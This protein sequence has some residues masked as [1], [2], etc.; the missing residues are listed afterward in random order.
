M[1]F[2][3]STFGIL[4]GLMLAVSGVHAQETEQKARQSAEPAIQEPVETDNSEKPL[5]DAEALIKAGKPAEAYIL[6]EPLEFDRA[7]EIRFDYLLGIAALDS[8]KPDKATLAFERVLAEDPEYAGARLDMARAYYQLGDLSRAKT[9]FETVLNQNPS[10]VARATI[11][12]YLDSIAGFETVRK[13]RIVGY[14]E[15]AFGRDTNVNNASDFAENIVTPTPNPA[16]DEIPD[17]YFGFAAGGEINHS[18]NGN[19]RLYAGADMIKHNNLKQKSFN[20]LYLDE[21]VGVIYG[22]GK[23]RY[24]V[25]MEGG[26]KILGG[27]RYRNNSGFNAEWRH[28][29]GNSN[30]LN[31]FGQYV[32]YRFVDTAMQSND[33]NQKVAGVGWLHVLGDAVST[34]SGSLYYGTENDVGPISLFYPNGGRTD[35]TM[36]FGGFRIGGQVVTGERVKLFF[37]AGEQI[38]NYSKINPSSSSYRTDRQHELT[39]GANWYLDNLWILRPQITYLDNMSNVPAYTFDRTD[40]S[41]TIRRNL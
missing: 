16:M 11:E 4:S 39:L 41:L 2:A 1:R 13:T 14:V 9:E 37:I 23:D 20:T 31:V 40:V 8:D 33:I 34:L 38:G 17:D 28:A 3:T 36:R 32:R 25:G 18:L 21:R 27:A 19:W 12:K 29:V 24:R 10:E 22:T 5:I 35:G 7:G 26:Q 30:Q 6:L 15:G